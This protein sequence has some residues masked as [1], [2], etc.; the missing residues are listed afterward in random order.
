MNFFQ[1]LVTEGTPV[2][3]KRWISVTISAII[4]YGILLT[5]VK[6]EKQVEPVLRDA[7]IFVTLM[8]GVATIPQ[9]ASIIKGGSGGDGPK[10]EEKTTIESKTQITKSE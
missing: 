6:Y 1:S 3:H 7:M 8:S 9:I 10:S 2:S 5:I 4:G